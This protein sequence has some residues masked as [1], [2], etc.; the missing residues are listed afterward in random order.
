MDQES[1]PL[2]LRVY[3][4]EGVTKTQDAAITRESKRAD[5]HDDAI[6]RQA[7][8]LAEHEV[9]IH[10]LEAAVE[11]ID[12]SVGDLSSRMGRMEKGILLLAAA[13]VSPKLG[14]PSVDKL[15]ATAFAFVT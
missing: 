14:G 5:R 15:V 6:G 12:T 1:A 10:K 13:V 7:I 11:K 8:T 2:P 4:L 9:E 3:G